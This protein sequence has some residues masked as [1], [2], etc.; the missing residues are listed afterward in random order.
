MNIIDSKF[1][2]I[3]ET[4]TFFFLLNILWIGMCLP[5]ITIFPATAAMFGVLRHWVMNKDT[6][7]FIPY[8]RFFK[9]NFKQSFMAGLLF[10]VFGTVFY[11]DLMLIGSFTSTMH[12]ILLVFL[13]LLGIIVLFTTIYLFPV[14]VHYRLPFWMMIKTAFLLSIK[15]FPTTILSI[16]ILGLMIILVFFI[17]VTLIFMFSFVSYIVFL[18]CY[19]KFRNIEKIKNANEETPA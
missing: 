3:L 14:M 19:S 6:S 10:F 11:V 17:P 8:F 4:I 18:L 5:V 15:F 1:Y 7:I 13:F 9:E 16:I 12:N 2:R